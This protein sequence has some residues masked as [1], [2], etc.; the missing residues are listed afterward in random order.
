MNSVHLFR[1]RLHVSDFVP[2]D[3]ITCTRD[4]SSLGRVNFR[5]SIPNKVAMVD[6]D[7]M[8]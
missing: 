8:D 4:G 3:V 2:L 1:S 5:A 7:E 6:A